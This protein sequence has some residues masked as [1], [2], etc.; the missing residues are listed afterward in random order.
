MHF[1]KPAE[2]QNV[3]RLVTEIYSLEERQSLYVPTF[4]KMLFYSK[5][6]YINL[7]LNSDFA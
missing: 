7:F 6:S 1:W 3:F 5:L 4:F 2:P